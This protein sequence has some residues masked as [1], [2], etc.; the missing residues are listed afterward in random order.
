MRCANVTRARTRAESHDSAHSFAI[1]ENPNTAAAVPNC[2]EPI[3]CRCW[4]T[5][6]LEPAANIQS[7]FS[8]PRD[9]TRAGAEVFRTESVVGADRNDPKRKRILLRL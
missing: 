8:G 9:Q 1:R 5:T 3:Q 7:R 2:H 6:L 4:Q